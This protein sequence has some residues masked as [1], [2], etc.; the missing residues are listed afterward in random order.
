MERERERVKLLFIKSCLHWLELP[1]E[2]TLVNIIDSN[3]MLRCTGT[4][5]NVTRPEENMVNVHL[6]LIPTAALS[7]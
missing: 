2:L 3:I 5:S 7:V 6:Y 4:N 1:S